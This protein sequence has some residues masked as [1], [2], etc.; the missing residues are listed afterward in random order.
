MNELAVIFD[1]IGINTN[2]V[3]EAAG[4]KWNFHMYRPGLV[5]GHCIGVDP[6]YLMYKA[7]QMGHD[8]QVIA[9]GRRVN[10]YIPHFI[11]KKVVQSLIENGTN[12]GTSKVLVMG[13][14]F[15]QNVSDVRNSKVFPMITE[16][17]DYSIDVDLIDPLADPDEVK[18]LYDVELEN[19]AG[20]NYNAII[21]SMNHFHYSKYD[22]NFFK[23]KSAGKPLIFDVK[24]CLEH[25]EGVEY[26]SM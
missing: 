1:K 9:A 19:E 3:I 4:T 11:A 20:E 6:F 18:F 26:W 25:M 2:E 8:P 10:D 24:G 17:K 5:G 21:I 22:V 7:K 13:V 16:L 23:Q 14:T 15:K 12:P